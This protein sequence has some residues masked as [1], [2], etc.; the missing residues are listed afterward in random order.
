MKF[1]HL[2]ALL[3]CIF[4]LVGCLP[5]R[6]APD[7]N[8][9]KFYQRYE[10]AQTNWPTA[11]SAYMSRQGKFPVIHGLPAKPYIILGRFDRPNIPLFRVARVANQ[12]HAD[13]ILLAEESFI[14]HRIQPGL[15]IGNANLVGSTP[16]T[17]RD[18]RKLDATAYLIKYLDVSAASA[19]K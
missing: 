17:S 12:Q 16:W 5:D 8:A 10:G 14:E 2:L 6:I 19:V 4:A 11:A 15:I 13:A 18:M 9:A 3:L 7:G 1:I